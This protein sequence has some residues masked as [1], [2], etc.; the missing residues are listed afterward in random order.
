MTF[1]RNFAISDLQKLYFLGCY[2]YCSRPYVY[3]GTGGSEEA[4]KSKG[5]I[6][7]WFRPEGYDCKN[8]KSNDF[9]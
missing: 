6:A 7:Y 8:P 5:G 1:H 9:M 3:F 2:A 4:M